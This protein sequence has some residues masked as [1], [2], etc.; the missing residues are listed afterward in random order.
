MVRILGGT[1]SVFFLSINLLAQTPAP[2]PGPDTIVFTNGDK[3]AGKF[4]SSSGS[5]LKFKS[6]ALG[7][8]TIDWSKVKELNTSTKVA[9]LKKGVRLTRHSNPSTVPQGTLAVEGGNVQLAVPAQAPQSIPVADTNAIVDQPSFQKALENSPGFTHGW[10]GAITLGG[11]LVKATQDN[12]TFS[13]AINLVRT[14]PSESWMAPRNRTIFDFTAS[15]GE[16]SQPGTPTVKTSIY[17]ADVERDEYFTPRVYGFAAGAF[18]HNFSQGL[19][20]QQTYGGGIGWTVVE[21]AN[22]TLDLKGGVSYIRQQFEAPPNQ[23]LIGSTFAEHYR[24]K[25]K[26]GLIADQQLVFTPAWND[27]SAYTAAFSTLF[28]LPVYK[29]LGASTGVIDTF[30]ND[31]P[32]GFR[33]NSFQYTLGLT[34]TLP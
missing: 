28:T 7:D 1:L 2:A 10:T 6:D 9:V 20:L 17:H 21:G 26:R 3:L 24:R 4:I 19:D 13:G 11:T 33:K 32:P 34:Y 8:L 5:S 30:L 31:P 16:L 27:T 14:E 25:F 15:Y 29:H 22:Q 23:S 12:E 18:D